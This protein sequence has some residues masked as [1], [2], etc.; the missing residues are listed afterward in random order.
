VSA[1]PPGYTSTVHVAAQPIR[2]GSLHRQLCAWCGYRLVDDDTDL[3][4]SP[5]GPVAPL[6]WEPYTFVRVVVGGGMRSSAPVDVPAGWLTPVGFCGRADGLRLEDPAPP[7]TGGEVR[8]LR[9]VP[10]PTPA[11]DG[12]EP[13]P[14]E[15]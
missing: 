10:A 1:P 3:M 6:A 14:V 5:D 4:V 12:A 8:T 13:G 11:E 15:P 7:A 9:L 2:V